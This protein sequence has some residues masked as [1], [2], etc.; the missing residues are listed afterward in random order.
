MKQSYSNKTIRSNIEYNHYEDDDEY[1]RIDTNSYINN[2]DNHK[3][4][5]DHGPFDAENVIEN[6]IKT[7]NIPNIPNFEQDKQISIKLETLNKIL[8]ITKQFENEYNESQQKISILKN[9]VKDLELNQQSLANKNIADNN[10]QRVVCRKITNIGTFILSC[11]IYTFSDW[12]AH[13]FI[14][15][16]IYNYIYTDW[17][18]H[19]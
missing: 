8:S 12:I 17:N 5:I 4:D 11:S 1:D 18:K 9:K 14:Y 2:D 3:M 6:I 16:Y 19:E 15:L 10:C 7:G 13:T